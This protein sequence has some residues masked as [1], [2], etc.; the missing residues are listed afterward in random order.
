LAEKSPA[1]F[2]RNLAGRFGCVKY[3]KSG[4]HPG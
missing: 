1:T 4:I 3:A 2:V